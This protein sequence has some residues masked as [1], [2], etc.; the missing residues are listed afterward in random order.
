[1][2]TEGGVRPVRGQWQR[3]TGRGLPPQ[4]RPPPRSPPGYRAG[5]ELRIV[6]FGHVC[7]DGTRF[8]PGSKTP[9]Q[10]LLLPEPPD[11]LPMRPGMP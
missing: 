5:R 4:W 3:P 10:H 1:M 11:R 2:P 6:L 9:W 8:P 7:C